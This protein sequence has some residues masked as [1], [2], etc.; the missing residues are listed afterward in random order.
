MAHAG[1][2]AIGRPSTFDGELRWRAWSFNMRAY[3]AM[4]GLVRPRAPANVE[5]REDIIDEDLERLTA[6][7]RQYSA[8]L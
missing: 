6:Q 2:R 8:S 5:G 4:A 1:L 7:Q 3:L